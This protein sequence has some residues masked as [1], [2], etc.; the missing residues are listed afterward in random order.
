MKTGATT[1][2]RE[3]HAPCATVPFPSGA[4]APALSVELAAGVWSKLINDAGFCGGGGAVAAAP[5]RPP[6]ANGCCKLVP[7]G[8]D[9]A[10][11][12]MALTGLSPVGN[13]S[14][15][16]VMPGKPGCCPT[17]L[18]AGCHVSRASRS[19]EC[20]GAQT[21]FWFEWPCGST[22]LARAGLRVRVDAKGL[23]DG[24][25]V[26]G[27]LRGRRK[28][29]HAGLRRQLRLLWG[30]PK[31]LLL[32]LQLLQLLSRGM[33]RRRGRKRLHARALLMWRRRGRAPYLRHL[34]K[35]R[36]GGRIRDSLVLRG[37]GVCAAFQ[38]QRGA[39]VR[40][41][42]LACL[43]PSPRSPASAS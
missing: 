14:G 37:S 27:L 19:G 7:A 34:L 25:H 2:A 16:L 42:A 31:S 43:P 11:A 1:C 20:A 3:P 5:P 39:E 22:H 33:R 38:R 21:Q 35:G 23:E 41:P 36:N 17:P 28:G 24:A 12:D 29:L 15:M 18:S 6:F 9:M 30:R 4:K 10:A 26:L 13:A 32:N 40:G 8:A